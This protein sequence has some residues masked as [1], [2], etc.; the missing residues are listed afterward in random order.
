MQMN[1]YLF[2]DGRCEA[3]FRFYAECLGGEFVAMIT[4][5]DSPIA[6][7][8]PPE[9]H[10]QILHARL[11][12]GD[13]MLMGSDAPP[14]RHRPMQGFCVSLLVADAAEA[15]R[16]FQALAADGTVHMEL[17]ETFWAIRFGML[18]DRFGTPWMIGCERPA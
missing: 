15:E 8:T 3:A 6:D 5:R 11:V 13:M 2:F 9:R 7:Q 18:V 4:H 1:P 12:R 14:E 10:D 16:L 17:Q